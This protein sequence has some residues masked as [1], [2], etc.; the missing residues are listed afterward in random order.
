MYK[1]GDIVVRTE[2]CHLVGIAGELATIISLPVNHRPGYEV[3]LLEREGTKK[4]HRAF[5]KLYKRREP[6]WRV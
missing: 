6:D 2:N 1:V 4:W 5:F 3:K